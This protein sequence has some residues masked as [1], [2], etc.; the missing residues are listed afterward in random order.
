MT[1]TSLGKITVKLKVIAKDNAEMA[2]L[3][4]YIAKATRNC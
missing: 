1:I 2:L 3:K 4:L